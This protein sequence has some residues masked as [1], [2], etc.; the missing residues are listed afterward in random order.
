MPKYL[1]R[2]VVAVE[3]QIRAD[4]EDEANDIAIQMLKDEAEEA[5]VEIE[6]VDDEDAN[7]GR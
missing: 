2:A 3:V 1:V 7:P 5:D 4:S 6:E